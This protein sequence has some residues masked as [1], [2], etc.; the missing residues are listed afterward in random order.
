MRTDDH[1]ILAVAI[2]VGVLA[3]TRAVRLI[4]DDDYPP[5]LWAKRHFVR[6]VGEPWSDVVE[7][8]WCA[9]PYVAAPA[10]AWFALLIA[11]PSWTWLAWA[12]WLVNSWAAVSWVAAYLS[13]RDIPPESR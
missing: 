9:A 7:C 8:P 12:W 5:V 10:V 11:Q 3:V 2:L 1:F 4:V 13:L 6:R